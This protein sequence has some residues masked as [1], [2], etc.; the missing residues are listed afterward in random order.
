MSRHIKIIVA[1]LSLGIAVAAPAQAATIYESAAHSDQDP[2][3][4]SIYDQSFLGAGFT[5]ATTTTITAVGGE[6]DDISG[7]LFGA[8]VAL[9]AAG[10]VPS[11]APSDIAANTLASVIFTGTGDATD[12][13]A[14]LSVTLAAGNYALIFGGSGDGSAGM[15]AVDDGIVGSPNLF[16]YSDAIFGD[17]W[18]QGALYDGLRFYVEGTPAAVPETS[19][20]AM[21][22]LGLGIAGSALRRRTARM[23]PAVTL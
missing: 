18:T 15:T 1:A 8:I 11:F 10:D 4:Y 5:L 22:I 17:S 14:P 16:R 20:W 6:F 21:M 12:Q 23:L 3:D 9:P 13:T 2:G 19:T 7:N